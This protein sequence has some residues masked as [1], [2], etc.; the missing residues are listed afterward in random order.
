M[1]ISLNWI[2][3]FVDLDGLDIKDIANKFTL[4]CAEIEGIEEKGKNL[5]GIITARIE[6]ISDHPQSQKLHILKVNT[7]KEKLQVVCGAPNVRVGMVTAFAQVGAEIGDITIF[8]ASLVGVESFGM[9]CSAKELEISDDNSGI[10]DLGDDTEIGVDLKD[11]LPIEDTIIEVDNKSLTNRPDMWGHYGI[12]R[13][14]AAITGRKLKEY[15]VDNSNYSR[16]QRGALLAAVS[17]QPVG[18]DVSGA[19]NYLRKRWLYG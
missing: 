16:I 3:E 8:K 10:M 18:A 1:Y 5:K 11:I 7:G 19:G 13:E 17:G 9:C 15:T 14:I 12:A 6:E 2:K 4:S